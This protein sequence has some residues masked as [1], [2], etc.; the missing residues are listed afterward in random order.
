M[1]TDSWKEWFHDILKLKPRTSYIAQRKLGPL[2]YISKYYLWKR[3]MSVS[4]KK[5]KKKRLMSKKMI[6]WGGQ[7]KTQRQDNKL[8]L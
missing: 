6:K 3:P 8:S 2:K 1:K 7:E 5:K 4:L